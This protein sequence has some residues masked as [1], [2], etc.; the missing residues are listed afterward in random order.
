MFRRYFKPVVADHSL[1]SARHL[2]LRS[3]FT[4]TNYLIPFKPLFLRKM[5]SIK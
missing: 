3:A 4:I 5:L 2:R 1:K